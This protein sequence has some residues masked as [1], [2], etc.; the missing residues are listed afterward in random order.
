MNTDCILQADYDLAILI[1]Q[2]WLGF[3]RS[4]SPM[5]TFSVGKAKRTLSVYHPGNVLVNTGMGRMAN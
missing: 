5:I 3:L 4:S 2:S 1:K